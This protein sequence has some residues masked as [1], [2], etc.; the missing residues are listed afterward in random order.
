MMEAAAVA[1]GVA[2]APTVP[3]ATNTKTSLFPS[4]RLGSVPTVA[5][6]F[7]LPSS[8][9]S[10]SRYFLSLATKVPTS[11]PMGAREAIRPSGLI[12]P[13]G[14]VLVDLHVPVMEKEAKKSEASKLPQVQLSKVDLEWVQVVAEGWASP[15]RGFMRQS[16]Y[17]QALHFNSLR[18]ADGSLVNMSIPIVLAIDDAKKESLEGVNAV[19]LV[20]PSGAHVAILR[21]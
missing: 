6:L 5:T 18:I 11:A 19:T 4:K 12:A 14:G 3:A 9:A 8:H 16:E 17:L 2:R 7:S 21:K 13:D 15:L 10:H 20:G 1:A